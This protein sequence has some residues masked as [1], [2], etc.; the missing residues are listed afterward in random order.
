[1]SPPDL[2]RPTPVSS[3][4]IIFQF[5]ILKTYMYYVFTCISIIKEHWWSLAL[6]WPGYVWRRFSSHPKIVLSIFIQRLL[7]DIQCFY[8]AYHID[9]IFIFQVFPFTLFLT[10]Q[11]SKLVS[12]TVYR[13]HSL[14]T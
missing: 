5:L 12:F 8:D 10:F 4:Y 11:Y 3:G 1:M 2:L 9:F 13:V 6:P 14:S 7:S